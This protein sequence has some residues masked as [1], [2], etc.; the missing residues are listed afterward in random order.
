MTYPPH[1]TSLGIQFS[2]GRIFKVLPNGGRVF[3]GAVVPNAPLSGIDAVRALREAERLLPADPKPA[4]RRRQRRPSVRSLVKQAER[5]GKQV[6]S[7][8]MADGTTLHFGPQPEP[9]ES[10]PWLA[11]LC[12]DTQP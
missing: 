6:T 1:S 4:S 8:T 7:V 2:T 5:S 10:N 11:D 12:K 9:I 3:T